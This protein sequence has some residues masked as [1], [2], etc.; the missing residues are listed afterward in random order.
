MRNGSPV[1]RQRWTRPRCSPPTVR[2]SVPADTP[3]GKNPA[4]SNEERRLVL[5]RRLLGIRANPPR[6][7]QN[8]LPSSDP[9]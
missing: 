9:A 2:K 3:A 4:A 1:A 6:R 5:C 8:S 7:V